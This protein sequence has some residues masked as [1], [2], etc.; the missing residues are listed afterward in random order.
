MF[1][2]ATTSQT[3]TRH[4]LA[5]TDQPHAQP[6]NVASVNELDSGLFL[7]GT[8]NRG[9]YL[10]E[11]KPGSRIIEIMTRENG[12]KKIL[13]SP[14]LQYKLQDRRLYVVSNPNGIYR[15]RPVN[16]S[17]FL[18]LNQI[19][20]EPFIPLARNIFALFADAHGGL[21]CSMEECFLY[22]SPTGE[23]SQ[24]EIPR[25]TI[26]GSQENAPRHI[27]QTADG[28]I[29]FAA[30]NLLCSWLPGESAVTKHSP[31]KSIWGLA[32]TGS[33]L[34]IAHSRG[35]SRLEGSQQELVYPSRSTSVYQDSK[36][37]LWTG[38]AKGLRRQNQNNQSV[39]T[40]TLGPD[41][42]LPHVQS[43]WESPEGDI[44]CQNRDAVYMVRAG[45]D[46]AQ[47]MVTGATTPAQSISYRPPT[48]LPGGILLYDHTLGV[49]A[50]ATSQLTT[51]P[52]P[53]P[54][55][56]D[57]RIFDKPVAASIRGRLP[58]HLDLDYRQNYLG[59]GFSTPGFNSLRQ[60]RYAY[61]L[62]GVDK[63]WILAES[64]DYATYAHLDPGE[65]TFLVREISSP[66]PPTAQTFTIIPPWWLTPWAKGGYALALL[67]ALYGAF[68]LTV[69]AQAGRI[70]REM[71]ETLV[72]QD[73]LTGI[74]NRRKFK[75]V[76]AAEKSR[77]KR[78]R[79][80]L[81]LIMIDVDY[82]KGFNDR[83]GH[84]AGD[85]A[86]RR[87]A[88]ALR[89]ALRRPEDFVARYGGEEFVVVLP[90]TDRQGA[91][92]VAQ[93]IQTAVAEANIA[94][95]GSPL[96]DRVTVSLGI[97]SFTPETDMHIESGLFSADQAL[98]H[99]KRSGRNRFFY[100][101]LTMRFSALGE[102]AIHSA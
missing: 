91:E 81:A 62:E 92:R 65:Y 22:I 68:A 78:F 17:E 101:A 52:P 35:V 48:A 28:R 19:E 67:A 11:P 43:Y 63:D 102:E 1:H 21:I 32:S 40:V 98:Y 42:P 64:R 7:I 57:L 86:L 41:S 12:Q 6:I 72:M 34:W 4:S 100:K 80:T 59:F 24:I 83:F 23:R 10:C 79:C 44:W 39:V 53:R 58:A 99:A 84:P 15:S 36:G 30:C 70:R 16:A 95:P 87:I 3:L 26:Q 49:L 93:K 75:E 13:P 73:P 56:S 54:V 66:H 69:R 2:H 88:R 20:V 47:E 55:I 94:Y 77:C 5:D 37:N 14:S 25:A 31:P 76:L 60:S 45:S 29:W 85:D 50:V 71:L 9:A 61:K 27:V 38:D 18:Y 90:N 89:D 74:P 51:P 97:S 96:S 82:F 8:W 33:A 46:T